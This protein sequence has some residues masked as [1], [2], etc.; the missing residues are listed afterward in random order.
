MVRCQ[1]VANKCVSRGPL[2]LITLQ[3][4]GFGDVRVSFVCRCG[5]LYSC[6]CAL[7]GLSGVVFLC[8]NLFLFI[9]FTACPAAAFLLFSYLYIV[10]VWI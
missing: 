6:K 9:S 10:K 3:C 1:R 7:A 5:V 8:V 4:V 2:S